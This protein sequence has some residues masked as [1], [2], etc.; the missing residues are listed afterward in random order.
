MGLKA[1]Q[2]GVIQAAFQRAA[3][4]L[5]FFDLQHLA[6]PRLLHQRL[7]VGEQ[8]VEAELAKPLSSRLKGEVSCHRRCAHR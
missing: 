8:A 2:P 7:A 4:A 3:G 1:A 6:E 5:G